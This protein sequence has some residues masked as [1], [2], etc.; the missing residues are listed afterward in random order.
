MPV[1]KL[2]LAELITFKE[3]ELP[4]HAID[5]AARN[6]WRLDRWTGGSSTGS[7]AAVAAGLVTFALGS[8]SGGSIST[9]SAYCG[10][11]GL[12]PSLDAVP[13]PGGLH[14]TPTLERS[15]PMARSAEDCRLVLDVIADADLLEPAEPL[16][17]NALR[18]L[19]VAFHEPD[20]EAGCRAAPA[21]PAP[22]RRA[23]APRP[24]ADVPR[25]D[26]AA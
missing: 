21:G 10:I 22:R 9:P 2:A 11:T 14:G 26:A 8:D 17:G 6:P 3:E 16:D 24:R 5:G 20:V 19:R 1:A 18:G 4:E 13:S 23:C 7:A 15:G 12:R 25:S